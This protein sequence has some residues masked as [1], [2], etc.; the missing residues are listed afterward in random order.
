MTQL[1]ELVDCL[2]KANPPSHNRLEYFYVSRLPLEWELQGALAD[3]F[4]SLGAVNSALDIYLRLHMWEKV[5]GCYQHLELRH[6]VFTINPFC[7]YT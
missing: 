2:A 6:K 1:Q 7:K 5:I 3:V 4:V